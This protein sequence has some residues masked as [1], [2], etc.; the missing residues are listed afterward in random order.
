MTDP[1]YKVAGE[2]EI[3]TPALLIFPERVEDN[4][5]RMISLAG[6][7]DK[8]RPHVKTH[9]MSEVVKLKIKH[10]I[11]RFKCST[12]A[13]AEM[14]AQCG[15]KDIML[16]MQPVGPHIDRFFRL[17]KTY[18][19]SRFSTIVDDA[20]IADQ[21]AAMAAKHEMETGLWLDINNGMNR[22]GI[23]PGNQ[24]LELYRMISHLPFIAVC[25]LH[26][27]D[28]HIHDRDPADRR[29]TCEKD[30]ASVSA[31]IKSIGASGLQV[32]AI[33]AGGT[34][35]FP[36]HIQRTGIEVSPGTCVLWDSGYQD[37][38][39]DFDFLPSAVLMT[40]IVS[41]PSGNLICLD[42]GHKAIA[43]EM[44][45]PRVAMLNLPVDRYVSHNEEH[46]VIESPDAANRKPGDVVYCIPWHICPTV[47]RYPFAY[48]V[49]N[50]KIAGTWRI[51]ARDREITI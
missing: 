16:A 46:L 8:L 7:P 1:W 45:H 13:E 37:Q 25:G 12:L 21:L 9:K 17:Q 19:G 14:T 6:G 18:P 20:A 32:P 44:P 34:P 24:A 29:R 43:A 47:P 30:F 35:T 26:V 42:L 27:Y 10:G 51:D 39:R 2:A 38:F 41:K 31:L 23:I 33:V 49:R 28:G 36:L 48:V 4:I 50:S 11:S 5:L 40:R 22:T 3:S 15:G